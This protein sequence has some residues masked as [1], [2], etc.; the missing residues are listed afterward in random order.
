MAVVTA[1]RWLV[2]LFGASPFVLS[3]PL[4]RHPWTLFTSV[5][6]HAGPL[7]LLSNAVALV[8]VGAFLERRTT[9]LRFHGFF[10]ATGALAG[11]AQV[12]LGGLLALGPVGVLGASGAVFGCLGYLLAGNRVAGGL[13]DLLPLSPRATAAVVVVLAGV[14]VVAASPP[15]SALVAHFVGLFL[16]LVAG[17]V[18]L[19][20]A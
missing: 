20:D 16:G 19:L 6:A 1:L 4:S 11:L 3:L 13:Y 5:Y 18:R 9:R 15:G 8:L 2:G 10:L 17:R 12:T 14:I 7:H